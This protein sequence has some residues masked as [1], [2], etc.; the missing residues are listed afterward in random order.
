VALAI[1][2]RRRASYRSVLFLTT[3]SLT[4]AIMLP[5]TYAVTNFG[6]LFR[7]R[8]MVL[9]TAALL[10]LAAATRGDTIIDDP[11]RFTTR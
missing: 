4:L 11:A 2:L 3:L 5:M 7:L 10:P 1:T 8:G 9:A 6:T